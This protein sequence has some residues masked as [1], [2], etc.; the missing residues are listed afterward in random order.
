MKDLGALRYFLSIEVA[1]STKGYLSHDNVVDIPIELHVMF[2]A[3]NGGPLDDPTW[4]LE[5][6]C[7]L[8]YLIVPLPYISYLVHIARQVVQ[9]LVLLIVLPCY[10]FWIMFITLP[11]SVSCSFLLRALFH[12]ELDSLDLY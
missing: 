8:N 9:L 4:Y 3:S 6:V 1:S 5:L 12:F 7:C 10:A 2:S 11:T